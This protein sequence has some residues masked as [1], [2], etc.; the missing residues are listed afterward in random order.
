M[1]L[2]ASG[3]GLVEVRHMRMTAEQWQAAGPGGKVSV[4]GLRACLPWFGLEVD[5]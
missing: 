4:S 2:T 3:R 1:S 5:G